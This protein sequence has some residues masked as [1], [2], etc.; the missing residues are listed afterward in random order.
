MLE[1]AYVQVAILDGIT[2]GCGAAISLP[3][4][5]RVVT[6]KTVCHFRCIYFAKFESLLAYLS[7]V[8]ESIQLKS[9]LMGLL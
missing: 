9:Y 8:T 6:D 3:G 5:F 1:V 7:F 4:M 2:M